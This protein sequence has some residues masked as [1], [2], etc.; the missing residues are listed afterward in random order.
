MIRVTCAIIR[1]ED[2]EILVVQRGK[3][4]DLPLKWEFPGGKIKTGETDEECIIREIKEELAMDIVICNRMKETKFNYGHKEIC[5]IPFICDTLDELPFLTE[6]LAYKW[7]DPGELKNTDFA[8]ADILVAENYLSDHL[9]KKLVGE[10]SAVR[11]D[12]LYSEEELQA[13]V[14][15]MMGIREAEWIAESAIANGE[16]LG[17]LLDYSFSDDKKLA[18]RASWT[19]SKVHDKIPEVVVP[20][21]TRLIESLD[22][23]DNE[24]VQRSFLRIVSLSDLNL[25]SARNQGILADHCFRMMKSGSSAIAIKA[26]SMEIIYK[27]T[28]IYPELANELSATVNILDGEVPAGVLARARIILKKLASGSGNL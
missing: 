4:M 7:I 21:L 13:M 26:Y 19:L 22:N 20:H 8:G 24:S 23:I 18:F 3:E 10:K 1:N 6:H 17:K 14:S 27:L 12:K 25:V 15:N 11:A 2:D 28:K 5:L 9:N 16:I